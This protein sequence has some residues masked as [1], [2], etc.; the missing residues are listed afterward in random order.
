MFWVPLR[1]MYALLMLDG[2]FS[3]FVKCIWSTVSFSF[4]VSLLIFYMDNPFIDDSGV[5]KSLTIILFISPFSSVNIFS[6]KYY[7]F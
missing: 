7:V 5:S 2:M 4:T 6:F 1:R 3:V